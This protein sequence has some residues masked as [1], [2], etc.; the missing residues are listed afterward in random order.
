[1]KQTTHPANTRRKAHNL[2]GLRNAEAERVALACADWEYELA[3][4]R[5]DI[6][7]DKLD[8]EAAARKAEYEARKAKVAELDAQYR[9]ELR[10]GY[11]VAWVHGL[12]DAPRYASG[13]GMSIHLGWAGN[14]TVIPKRRGVVVMRNHKFCWLKLI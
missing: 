14:T 2:F 11:G 7:W 13:E 4:H 8:A 12:D 9:D 1:M 6:I 3:K 10:A 5:S